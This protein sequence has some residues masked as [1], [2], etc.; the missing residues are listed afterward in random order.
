MSVEARKPVAD[1][2]CGPGGVSHSIKTD[3]IPVWLRCR[4]NVKMRYSF[5]K[6]HWHP[7]TDP[8]QRD[9]Q[10]LLLC[11]VCGEQERQM[12]IPGELIAL[13]PSPGKTFQYEL[14]AEPEAVDVPNLKEPAFNTVKLSIVED[15]GCAHCR[16]MFRLTDNTLHLI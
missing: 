15:M 2:K 4:Q 1:L 3:G 14:L 7:G 12:R 11:P 16:Q 6:A 9:A 10:L 8:Q 13:A 5:I